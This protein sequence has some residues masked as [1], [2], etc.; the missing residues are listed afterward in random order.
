MSTVRPVDLEFIGH[1]VDGRWSV[2]RVLGVGGMGTVYQAQDRTTGEY[3]ALKRLRTE[4]MRDNEVV[5]RFL[6]EGESGAQM[7]HENIVN[8]RAVGQDA[9]DGSLYLVQEFLTGMD[10]RQRL[11]LGRRPEA[12]EVISIVAPIIDGLSCA[13]SYGVVHRDIKPANI[14]LAAM[15]DGRVVPKVIDFG[16]SKILGPLADGMSKTRTGIAVGTPQYMSPEQL[17]GDKGLDERTDMF[18]VGVVLYLLLTG[19]HP[20]AAPDAAHVMLNILSVDPP[21]VNVIAPHLTEALADVVEK[22]LA[23]DRSQ[24]FAN[25]AEFYAALLAAPVRRTGRSFTDVSDISDSRVVEETRVSDGAD[26]PPT[27]L[28]SHAFADSEPSLPAPVLPY[29]PSAHPG[30][31]DRALLVIGVALFV[32][33]IAT[34]GLTLWM[35]HTTEIAAPATVPPMA[36]APTTGASAPPSTPLG[37]SAP[38]ATPLR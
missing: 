16:V 34:L 36:P 12:E 35:R 7:V 20:F 3:V 10:L 11:S 29:R 5:T 15:P 23:K 18:A 1:V 4:F 37:A 33:A 25:M 8:V 32:V 19:K 26:A 22:A 28:V 21:R 17:R 31:R 30:R 6:R 2:L 14:F 38:P 27:E 24:R 9:Q 13:H